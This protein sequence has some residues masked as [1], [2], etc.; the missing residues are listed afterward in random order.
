MAAFGSYPSG[1]FTVNTAFELGKGMKMC[2]RNVDFRAE[3]Y[4]YNI[5]VGQIGLE[6]EASD[7]T[8][9]SSACRSC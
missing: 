7:K 5:L 6:G 2:P 1:K 3:V 8:Y 4:I 9:K